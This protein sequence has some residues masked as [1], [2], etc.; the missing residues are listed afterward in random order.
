M[1]TFQSEMITL[2]LLQST[3]QCI[4][5]LIKVRRL[6]LCLRRFLSCNVSAFCMVKPVWLKVCRAAGLLL[7][8]CVKSESDYTL[9]ITA[10]I[11]PCAQQRSLKEHHDWVMCGWLHLDINGNCWGLKSQILLTLIPWR[12]VS[13]TWHFIYI[14]Y[15]TFKNKPFMSLDLV[16]LRPPAHLFNT[17]FSSTQQEETRP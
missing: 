8:F 13:A 3:D 2:P 4:I 1:I 16:A 10:L 11:R 9:W 15:L 17:D 5:I 6:F 14:F 7:V 12:K